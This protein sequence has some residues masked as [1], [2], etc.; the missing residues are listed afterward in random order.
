MGSGGKAP[1]LYVKT[2]LLMN[3]G[4]YGL[5]PVEKYL[6]LVCVD[7]SCS[8][9]R[10]D[11]MLQQLRAGLVT[12]SQRLCARLAASKVACSVEL[13]A[14]AFGAGQLRVHCHIFLKKEGG[15]ITVTSYRL[16][17][18]GVASHT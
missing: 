7:T 8:Q 16:S 6:P 5:V 18:S 2:A 4:D 17:S 13:C 1:K 11:P 3:Q 9:L 14:K 15:R 10:A 12:L